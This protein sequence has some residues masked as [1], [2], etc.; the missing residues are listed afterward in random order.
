MKAISKQNATPFAKF[1]AIKASDLK[2][3]TF[4]CYGTLVNVRTEMTPPEHHVWNTLANY[5]TYHTGICYTPKEVCDKFF[6]SKNLERKANFERSAGEHFEIEELNVY[7]RLIPGADEQTLQTAAEIFRASTTVK[8]KLFPGAKEFLIAAK[9]AGLK[10]FMT[11]NAQVV[12]TRPEFEG[13]GIYDLFDGDMER[14]ISSD[15][16]FAKPSKKF[17]QTVL[18]RL[19]VQPHEVCNFGNYKPDDIDPPHAL[20]MHTCL[21]NSERQECNVPDEN[22][23]FFLDYPPDSED[24]QIEHYP[25]VRL[26]KYFFG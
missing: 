3:I 7:R 13:L 8:L 11:S 14:G 1:A 23:D 15:T 9:A 18:D 4:D 19:G 17:F 20:G 10:I 22:C 2:A 6:V 26:K 21:L 5:I 25:F 16:F 12:Y 24:A